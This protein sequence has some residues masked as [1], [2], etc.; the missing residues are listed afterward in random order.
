[1]DA[2]RRKFADKAGCNIEKEFGSGECSKGT[3]TFTF[4]REP[5]G[6]FT[7]GYT[8]SLF[9]FRKTDWG[10][11]A[12]GYGAQPRTESMAKAAAKDPQ[13][14]LDNILVHPRSS[15]EYAVYPWNHM[16]LQTS[17]AYAGG[18]KTKF[19]FVGKLE[20]ADED[21]MTMLKRSGLKLAPPLDPRIGR[22]DTRVNMW[23]NVTLRKSM[24]GSSADPFEDRAKL[25]TFLTKNPKYLA[26]VCYLLKRDYDCFG[27]DFGKCLDGSALKHAN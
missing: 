21:W 8:E 3:F 18:T 1:M 26:A 17:F 6:H 11:N 24:H 22:R 19:D 25:E 27:Y 2:P 20:N 14:F 7:S 15:R 10:R 13:Y 12:S 9:R 23:L 16:D 4:V 5:L